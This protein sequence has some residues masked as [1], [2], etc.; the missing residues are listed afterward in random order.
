MR[1]LVF[2]GTLFL[3]RHLV[4][5]ALARGHRV[6]LFNRGTRPGLWPDVEEIRG[7]RD[8]GLGALAAGEW[9]VAFDPS[10]Y[11]PRVVGA[12]AR[13]LA[14][15]VDHYAFV[16]S[17]SVY[18]D[19]GRSGIDE[20]APVATIADASDEDV[21]THYGALKVLCERAAEDAMPGRVLHVRAGLIVGPFDVT[22]RFRYWVRRVGEGGEVLA[23]GSPD[24]R[25]QFVDARD[26]AD[27]IV[28][29]AEA[30]RAGVFNATGPADVLT[31]GDL[32]EACRAATG[33]DA[34]F[35]W[36]DDAFLAEHEVQA[37]TEMPLWLPADSQGLLELDA[38]RA[39]ASGLHFR[40]LVET[41]ADVARAGMPPQATLAST[42]SPQA[43]LARD[44]ERALLAAWRGSAPAGRA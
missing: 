38:R 40:P 9:D 17:A 5:A 14:D 13:L 8:G 19:F 34:R 26:L 42:T 1:V 2:G 20:H 24:R 29:M 27:W 23:P 31:M 6:T 16:S 41:I 33:S 7:D 39:I 32:L 36:V 21:K 4:E 43:G 3:G 44:P 12:S 28:A 25:V 30:R 37:F 11:V 18:A 22:G 10:G 15:R 35:T